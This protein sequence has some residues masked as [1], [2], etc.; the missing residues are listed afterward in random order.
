[1]CNYPEN[2]DAAKTRETETFVLKLINKIRGRM[3]DGKDVVCMAVGMMMTMVVA[4]AMVL[5]LRA[6][7]YTKRKKCRNTDL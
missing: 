2:H 1:M 4:V 3:G 6:G 5:K 7:I